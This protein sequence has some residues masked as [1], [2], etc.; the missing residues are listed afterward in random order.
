MRPNNINR[1]FFTMNLL[2]SG[3]CRMIGS[4][5]LHFGN[6]VK[7]DDLFALLALNLTFQEL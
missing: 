4:T 2:R 6:N 5:Y 7:F 3:F 1:G